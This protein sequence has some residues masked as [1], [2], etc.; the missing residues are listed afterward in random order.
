MLSLLV[1]AS[2]NTEEELFEIEYETDVV[3]SAGISQFEVHFQDIFGI[4]SMTEAFLVANNRTAEE[5]MS[6]VPKEA[7]LINIQ[8]S[9]S[10]DFLR[11]I[12]IRLFD[13]NSFNPTEISNITEIFF[14]EN[15]PQDQS[16]FINLLP[17]LPDVKDRL[18]EDEINISVRSQLRVPPP[19]TIE[20]RLRIT[21]A[22]R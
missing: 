13:G 3:F 15:I 6:I 21:F 9:Q 11:D 22:V 5:V 18:F 20:A 2:C 1:F 16:T 7:R 19:S 10:I 14:R 17:A 12:S 4:Q 8:S